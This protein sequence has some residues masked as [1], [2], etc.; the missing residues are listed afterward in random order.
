MKET[1]YAPRVV[2]NRDIP[3]LARV[4]GIMQDVCG[5]ERQIEWQN[6]RMYSITARLTG[7]PSGKGG[8]SGFDAAFAA[9]DGLKDEH[10]E[11]IRMYVRELKRAEK[12]INSIPSATMRTF[13]TM[14]Y[15]DDLPLEFIRKEL[16]MTRYG[17]ERARAAVEDAPSMRDVVWRERFLV[18]NEK[19]I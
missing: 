1:G 18:E 19:D 9:I 10:R 13:V 7:M 5:L 15:V 6:E 2:R 8:A 12:I 16:N 11:K 17:F 4:L 3:L 14:L